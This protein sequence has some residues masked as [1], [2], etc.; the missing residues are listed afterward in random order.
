MTTHF[1]IFVKTHENFLKTQ[2]I[3][4]LWKLKKNLPVKTQAGKADLGAYGASRPRRL[5]LV[6]DL[7]FSGGF[8]TRV[9]NSP[10]PTS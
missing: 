4:N 2:E 1:K 7:G 8:V 10:S 6:G 5:S 3:L 9:A